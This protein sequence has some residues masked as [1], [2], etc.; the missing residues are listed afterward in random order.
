MKK[1]LLYI[2]LFFCF[3]LQSYSQE[4]GVVAF[5]LPVRNSL[6]FNK[7]A[8]SPTFSFVR[9][10]NKH[11]SFS[12][13]RQWVQF[14]DAPQTY[15]FS[16]SGRLRE[17]IGAG[18]GLFQQDYGVLT[19]FGGVLN[20]AYNAV[21]DRDSNLTFGLNLGFYKSG[22]NKGKIITNFPDPSLNDVPSNS[23]L[24]IN[25]GLNYGT[26]FFDFGVSINNAV[27]YN[28]TTSRMI[29][30]NP[31]QSV[32]A[33]IL[34]TGYM[35]THGFFDQSK[36]STL[37]RSEFKKDKTVLSGIAMLNVPKG[38]WAQAGYN[39]LYGASAGIGINITKQIALE[40]NYEKAIGDLSDFGNSH[41]ITLAY[42]FKRQY[43]F[44]YADDEDE[45]QALITPSRRTR[46]VL[47]K[48]KSPNKP[49]VV[50]ENKPIATKEA[51]INTEPIVA[52][53][54]EEETKEQLAEEAKLKAEAEAQAK[55]EVEEKLKA[56]QE[57][58]AKADEEARI[59][60]EEMETIVINAPTD[61]AT[62]AM[63]NL[64]KLTQEAK[65]VT[66]ELLTKLSETA[67][68]RG[69]DLKD[70][71]EEN[72]L[73]EQGIYTEPKPFKSVTSENASLE[74]LKVQI[75]DIIKAQKI[76][77]TELENVTL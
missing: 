35:N 14:D 74:S 7:Y 36:F 6:K 60:L 29:E 59:K 18:I 56:E 20:F 42:K 76:R 72:D 43:R 62:L 68:K 73:S 58:K 26:T 75:D 4:N 57:A 22:I 48:R 69:Q 27:S 64:T 15:L 55:L 38:I 8:V 44:N 17:N 46:R 25:P 21:L 19:T 12:N 41:E 77:I 33:H 49:K 28:L 51:E 54:T 23:V 9:E 3:E 45:E 32:Q 1:Y 63:N 47:A 16:Y 66:R 13:K 40:Y 37:L 10:Q 31:E 30:D 5:V 34:Y 71:K 53:Q 70:L 61:D 50:R 67:A 65:I 39:T 52:A 2:V 24:T 11:I